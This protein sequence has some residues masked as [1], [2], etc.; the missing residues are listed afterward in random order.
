MNCSQF[1]PCEGR[2]EIVDA[3]GRLI[4]HND[5]I[6]MVFVVRDNA[7]V[8]LAG[9]SGYGMRPACELNNEK[10]AFPIVEVLTSISGRTMNHQRLTDTREGSQLRFVA[11]YTYERGMRH[12]LRIDQKD[13]HSGLLTETEFSM[14]PGVSAV[15]CQSRIASERRLP[16]EAV[17]SLNLTVPL[18]A[19]GGGVDGVEVYWATAHG[20]RKII[21]IRRHFARLVCRTSIPTLILV[22]RAHDLISL[23]DPL[24]RLERSFPLAF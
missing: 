12:V 5:D 19:A 6:C 23:R 9:L 21:G 24:G 14:F 22:F 11:A 17:S 3:D 2:T 18:D 20:P 13:E 1:T 16:V 10:G 7:P 4:W 15:S 8:V